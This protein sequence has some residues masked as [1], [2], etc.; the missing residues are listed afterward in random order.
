[1][2]ATSVRES[3]CSERCGPRSVGRVTTIEPCSWATRMGS[4][5]V[6]RSSP[7]GPFTSTRW[8]V[9]VTD[10][11]SGMGIGARPMRLIAPP[12]PDGADHLAA[13]AAAASLLAGQ[14]ALR[15][16]DDGHAHAAEHLGQRVAVDVDAAPGLGDA[17]QARDHA[18][19]VA[20]VL[21][22]H[23]QALADVALLDGVAGDVALL[24]EEA[25]DLGLELARGHLGGVVER[26]VGV[27]QTRQHVGDGIGQHGDITPTRRTWSA[28]G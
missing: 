7:L 14:E 20:V 1:M 4:T 10:T 2:L 11:P 28:R 13:D 25:S 22:A 19:P 15:G 27:P 8:P 6:W 21:E 24:L 18:A 9:M 3:P 16:R 5:T 12:L 23:D 26:E 17:L